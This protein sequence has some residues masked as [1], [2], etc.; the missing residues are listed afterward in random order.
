MCYDDTG[1]TV[2]VLFKEVPIPVC[3]VYSGKTEG[4]CRF[5]VAADGVA[6]VDGFVRLDAKEVHG[7]FEGGVV[8]FFV[9]GCV[10]G[11]EGIKVAGKTGMSESFGCCILVGVCYNA[12]PVSF[13]PEGG[14]ERSGMPGYGVS[15]ANFASSNAFTAVR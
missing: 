2:S 10:V 5:N 12:E 9:A 13:F 14:K 3:G 11:D 8:R 6:N 4:F 15:P 1:E 7:T